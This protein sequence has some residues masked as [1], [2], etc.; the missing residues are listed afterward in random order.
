MML[1]AEFSIHWHKQIVGSV[2]I[3]LSAAF[4]VLD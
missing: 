4:D 1:L 3:D 2:L